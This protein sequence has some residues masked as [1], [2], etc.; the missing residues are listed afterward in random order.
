MSC[1]I[2]IGRLQILLLET[3]I[4][5]YWVGWRKEGYMEEKAW[6]S[7]SFNFFD[8]GNLNGPSG[9]MQKNAEMEAQH[10]E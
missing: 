8:V 1:R 7:S 10:D 3:T 2:S 5:L 4:V 9:G 6:W